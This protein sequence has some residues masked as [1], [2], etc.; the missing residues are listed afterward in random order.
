MA[1]IRTAAPWRGM[2]DD[3]AL[4]ESGHALPFRCVVAHYLRPIAATPLTTCHSIVM[5]SG[6]RFQDRSRC[7]AL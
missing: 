7:D 3:G 2:Q 5:P 6:A 4:H 1:A